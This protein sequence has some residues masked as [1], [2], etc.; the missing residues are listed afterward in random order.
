M[1]ITMAS[2]IFV[3]AFASWIA[4]EELKFISEHNDDLK[5]LLIGASQGAAFSNAIM[6]HL[7]G[8]NKVYSI[9][10]GTFFPH[11]P[12]RV[13]TERTLAIDNNGLMP[14]PMC[15]RNLWAG[16]QAYITAPF[17]WIKYRW[18]GKPQK[19]TYCINAP[20]HDYNW[21]YPEVRK[22]IT[23]FLTANFGKRKKQKG[24]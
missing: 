19:F 22:K 20:G 13:I 23:D 17:R 2:A 7:N 11:V 15:H 1:R 24:G 18:Q 5:I 3:F 8:V 10:L 14:D 6:R 16:F 9:E 4:A 12:R 21:E